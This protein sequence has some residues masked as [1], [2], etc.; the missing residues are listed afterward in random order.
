MNLWAI[1]DVGLARSQNQDAY[2]AQLLSQERALLAVCD[3]MGGARAGNVA[4]RL[5]IDAF[6]A[7]V[8]EALAA[9]DEPE[10]LRRGL[11]DAA[12]AANAA[13][14]RRAAQ[15]PDC[16]G[17]GTTLVAA[18]VDAPDCYVLNV[19]DSRAYRVSN[20]GIRQITRD[21]SLVGDLVARGEITAEQARTHPQK[22]LIT[23]ALGAE[24]RTQADLFCETCEPGE[25]ILLCSD[26]LSNLLSDQE[27]LYEV[28][29]G[30]PPEDCCGRLLNTALSRG[31]P[32]NVTAVLLQM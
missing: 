15:D 13:V 14:C 19:G 7:A 8:M 9:S 30:G 6:S 1:T 21:H 31:A 24:K 18:L 3:G 5:A 32:D 28:L 25:F 11:L 12:D 29:H 26:G 20:E 27:L 22:N 4:S 10:A 2:C 17:M 16:A 23:R